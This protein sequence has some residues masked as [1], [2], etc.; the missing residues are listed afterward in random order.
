M[1][2]LTL[3]T[4]SEAIIQDIQVFNCELGS[5]RV[6]VE[7]GEPLFVARDLCQVLEYKNG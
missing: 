6:I 1:Q 2:D 3:N 7:N 4:A 5:I